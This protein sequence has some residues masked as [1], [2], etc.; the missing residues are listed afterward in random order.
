MR[1]G[2]R[3]KNVF[4]FEGEERAGKLGLLPSCF[5]FFRTGETSSFAFSIPF[6]LS[7]DVMSLTSS[8]SRPFWWRRGQLWGGVCFGRRRGG[9]EKVLDER[10]QDDLRTRA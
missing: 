5:V 8:C 9:E 10:K 7:R 3:V 1:V 6:A 2:G 4:F